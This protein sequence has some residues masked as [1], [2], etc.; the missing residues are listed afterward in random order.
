MSH[1]R[2]VIDLDGC[3]ASFNEAYAQVLMNESGLDP[4]PPG[5]EID[6]NWPP[7]W[8]WDRA[9]PREARMRA[10]DNWI[11]NGDVGFWSSL[12]PLPHA[13]ETVK[14]LNRLA[15]QGHEISFLTAREGDQAKWQSEEWLNMLGMKYPTVILSTEKHLIVEGLQPDLFVDDRLSTVEALAVEAWKWPHTQICLVDRPYNRDRKPHLLKDYIVVGSVLEALQ[16]AG[17]DSS[18]DRVVKS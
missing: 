7:V 15:G 12:D 11:R 13:Q 6:P 18:N 14:L 2:L 16:Q 17:L 9:F 8:D 10:W 1:K 4:L 3:L 5:W